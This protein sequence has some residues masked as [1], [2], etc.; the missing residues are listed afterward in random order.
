MPTFTFN[1]RQNIRSRKKL[2]AQPH[3]RKERHKNCSK[4]VNRKK[5]D[6]YP[7]NSPFNVRSKDKMMK[8]I[9]KIKGIRLPP[10]YFKII[11]LGIFYAENYI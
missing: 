5:N 3:R 4:Y 9:H 8:R 2:N 1:D 10:K 7:C 11:L 6:N